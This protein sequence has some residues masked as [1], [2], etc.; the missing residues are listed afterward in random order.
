[1]RLHRSI[2]KSTSTRAMPRDKTLPKHLRLGKWKII[3][4]DEVVVISGKDRGQRGMV[5]EV[6]RKTNSVYVRGLK[7][8]FKTVPKTQESPTGKI[9][10]EMP[11]HVSNVAL[12]DP[13]TNQP[14]KVRLASYVDPETGVK[15]K[16]R[17]AVGTGTYIP[18]K[19]D[20]SYQKTWRDGV[21]DTDPDAVQK[22]TFNAVPGIPPFP[23]DV[24]REIK[25]RYKKLF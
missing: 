16:R 12:V 23:E 13:S 5:T 10:K 14:T 11:I 17:Y 19:V 20:L 21:L 2:L 22:V 15:E 24:M 7:L 6:A 3:K 18:K 25:N 4:G 1:M 9:Q 8:A